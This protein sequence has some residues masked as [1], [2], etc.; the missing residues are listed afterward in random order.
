MEDLCMESK[1]SIS[2]HVEASGAAI[3]YEWEE[4]EERGKG[5]WKLGKMGKGEVHGERLRPAVD[6]GGAVEWQECGKWMSMTDVQQE[7]E[8]M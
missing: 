8:W 1:V 6:F 4:D 7:S 5:I 2:A 3:N